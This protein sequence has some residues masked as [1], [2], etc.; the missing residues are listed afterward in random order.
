MTKRIKGIIMN[1]YFEQ[2]GNL[3]PTVICKIFTYSLFCKLV[4]ILNKKI[5]RKE[6]ITSEMI[7]N[8]KIPN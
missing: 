4:S 2:S 6:Y 3:R 1:L 7:E 8:S 5:Y